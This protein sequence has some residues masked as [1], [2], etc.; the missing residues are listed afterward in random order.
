MSR[1]AKRIVMCWV[2]TDVI[3]CSL[4][5]WVLRREQS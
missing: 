1:L 2:A 4:L 5:V 3:S